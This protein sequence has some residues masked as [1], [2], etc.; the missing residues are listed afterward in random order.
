MPSLLSGRYPAEHG[1]YRTNP[2]DRLPDDLALVSERF[3]AA[4]WMTAAFVQQ[5]QL[6]PAFGFDR[7]WSRYGN[8]DGPAPAVNEKV[9]AWNR[10]FRSVPRLVFVHYLDAHGPYTPAP[11]FRPAD[12]PPTTLALRPFE[13]WRATLDAIERGTLVPTAEDWAH[14]RGLYD[15]ELRQ[16]DVRLGALFRALDEDGTLDAGWVVLTADHGERFGERGAGAHMGPPDE[17]VIAVPLLVRPPGGTEARAV[18]TVVQHVDVVP[19]LLAA[20][21]LPGDP[22]LPGRDLG[23]A[24]R[25]EALPDRPSFAEEWAADTHHATV[26]EGAWKLWRGA[27]PALYDLATDPGEA[28]DLSAERPD[29]V[30][31]LDGLLAAYFASANGGSSPV[32]WAKVD[33]AAAVRSGARW[34]PGARADGPAATTSE[35]TLR[36]LEALGYVVDDG[37]AAEE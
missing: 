23:P 9:L 5:P 29:V 4:G 13:K 30:A 14:L 10:L 16:L 32:D 19:T 6:D 22:R 18:D 2:P 33:W 7:G 36:A 37:G 31:R 20:A 28:R 35:E 1:L 21:G 25:G 34:T 12:L 8:D 26:R 27:T 3:A 11:R 17:T 24:L 15:G